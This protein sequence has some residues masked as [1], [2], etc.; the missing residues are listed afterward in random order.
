[1]NSP[2]IRIQRFLLLVVLSFFCTSAFGQDGEALFKSNCASCHYANA[3]KLIGPGLKDVHKRRPEDWLIK[4]IR[5]SQAVVKSGDPYAV[6]L[7]KEYNGAVMTSQNLSDAEIKAVLKYVKDFKDPV[8]VTPGPEAGKPE[9]QGFPWLLLTVTAILIFLAISLSK[10]QKSLESALRTKEGIPHPVV[11]RGKAFYKTWIRSN[12]KLIAAIIV[13]GGLIGSVQGWYALKDVG[14]TQGYEP[15][16]PIKFSH[17]LHAGDNGI[18][19]KYCHSGVEKSKHANIPSAILC[20]NCHKGIKKGPKYGSE[21]INKI[22]A[23]LDWDGSKYGPNQ[24][25]IQWVRVHNLPDLAYFNHSQHVV[26]G[27]VECA[28]CHGKVEEMEVLKQDQPLTMGWCI[29]CHRTTEVA[30]AGNGYYDEKTLENLHKQYGK[31]A[32]INVEKIGG[33]DCAR[34]HY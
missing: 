6:A 2:L 10:I 1:M 27:K 34:C 28:Q 22:Y 18:D 29:D 8:A 26:A 17:K 9:E 5:N 4:W 15:E 12:K 19:C 23:A 21:E 25:P 20:M 16:Q 14:V 11:L 24:K 30:A 13:I 32:K 33:T 31:D 7:F 3:E